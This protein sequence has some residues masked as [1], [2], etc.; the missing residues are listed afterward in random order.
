MSKIEKLNPE[1]EEIMLQVKQEY[2]DKLFK[3]ETKFDKEA[4]VK[5]IEW[6]Y[7]LAKLKKPIVIVVDSPLAAQYGGRKEGLQ[8][9]HI[10]HDCQNNNA[11]NL[12]WVTASQNLKHSFEG[13]R[14]DTS[15]SIEH[16]VRLKG[17]EF[18]NSKLTQQKAN[19]IRAK[20]IPHHYS[21]N[22]LAKEYKVSKKL[23]LLTLQNKIWNYEI[24]K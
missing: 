2:L 17:E 24:T 22:T 14:R 19:E 20:Y 3:C 21:L 12:E 6:M 10:D 8:V 4:C 11:S 18:P 9:N 13:N 1:Q 7:S 5:G 15:K 23:I 16:L